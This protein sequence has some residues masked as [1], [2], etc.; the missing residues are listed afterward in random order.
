MMLF[1]IILFQYIEKPR[2]EEEE[3][4]GNSAKHT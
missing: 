3:K 1:I 4:R 2:I